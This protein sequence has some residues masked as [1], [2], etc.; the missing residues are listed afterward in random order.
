M[1]RRKFLKYSV[2]MVA[3]AACSTSFADNRQPYAL[4]LQLYTIRDAL[5]K[6]VK[7]TLK[8]ISEY[9]YREVEIYGYDGKF[10]GYDPSDFKTLLN[11]LNLKSPSG[12]F[13]LNKFFTPGSGNEELVRYT[14]LCISGAEKLGQ[15]YIVWPWLD[16]SMRDAES[17]K[18]LID[19]LN[20]IG[21]RITAAGLKFAYHNHNFEFVD[22]DGLMLYDLLL[23]RT[24][25]AIV[26]LEL[27]L[28]WA[29]YMK[30]DLTELFRKNPGR[31][32]LWHLKDRDRKDPDLHTF[33]GNGDIDFQAILPLAHAAGV[34]HMYVE[35]GNNYIPN[36]MA[37]VQK[38]AKYVKEYLLKG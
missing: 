32:E 25:P 1:K 3:A 18:K 14:D 10:Y 21:E 9:G 31:F 26:R 24:D 5:S 20:L 30:Q 28:Y 13:D 6:D 29:S 4:G 12:H 27:D 37:C 15:T 11:D 23:Q 38:S 16:P 2:T 36:D 19:Q 35:Q 8:K 34:R 33:M 7:G 22:H 17:F